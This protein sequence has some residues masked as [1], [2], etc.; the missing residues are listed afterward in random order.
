M[1]DI[2]KTNAAFKA[3]ADNKGTLSFEI[4]AQQIS[5]GI[6]EAFNKQKDK[7]NIPGF[8][9]GHVSKDMF[10][11]R[12]GEEALYEDALNAILPDVY[13]QAVNEA[14]LTVVGQPQILPD[15]LKK[16]GP[17]K[18]HAEVT[19]A[20]AVE[21]GDYKNLEVEKDSDQVTDEELTAEL[22]RLQKG[23]AELVPAKDGEA[24][25]TGDTVVIDF[26][27]SVDGKQFDGGKAQNFSLSLGSGQF[28]P[29]FEDQLVG[30]KV[31]EDVDVKVKFPSDY[32]AKD[33]AG[34]DAV[35]AVTIHE[36]KKLETPALD[37]EF[38]KD[39]DDSVSSLEE[40][41]AKTKE[42]LA[43]DKAEKSKDAFEDAAVQKAVD[44]AKV[45]GEKLPDE[46]LN[47]D[48]SRQMQTFFN[49]LAGQGVQPEM[50]FKITGSSQAQLKE[51]MTEGAPNRVK[52]N[53]VLEAIARAEKINPSDAD[54]N[55]E[56]KHLAAEYNI[57]EA[58][59]E[60]SVSVGLL[61]H[62]LKIQK[63]VDLIVSGAKAVE[64]K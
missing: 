4:P 40:L 55:D 25:A 30:H 60:K 47:D 10:L 23:E 61:S 62:D 29:G 2:I 59:V 48:V 45:S 37:N 53:L 12:F 42:K 33:L 16:G 54:I 41:K 5:N 8:R 64:K 43:K 11:A 32:Q 58:E 39:V 24:A 51:Q 18:I 21:L 19:L 14:D 63:A 38:A 46:L 36:L 44:A 1:V 20:P 56:I 50:Y 34:K 6:D 22:T 52:T 13:D 3:G 15:D 26:D 35:F 49:N 28:I 27:G 9:K 57:K 17:W 31:D 7:I